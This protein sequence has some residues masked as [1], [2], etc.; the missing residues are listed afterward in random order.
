MNILF[1]HQSFP[2]QYRHVLRY[3]SK[4]NHRIV[5]LGINP[6]T[7]K[8]PDNVQYFRYQ[9]HRSNTVGLDPW[10]VDIDSKLIRG[11]ACASA[12]SNLKDQGFTP[13]IICAHSG[14]GEA[15]FIKD[16]WPHVPLLSYQE[17]YYNA[18]GFDYDFDPELQ[19]NTDWT[20]T[21]KLRLKNSNPLLMLEQSDWN[22]TPTKFQ[23][24]CFPSSFHNR[25]SVIHDGIDTELCSPS[26]HSTGFSWGSVQ[27]SSSHKLVTFVNRHIEPYRG[28]HTFIRS[29]PYILEQNPD[30]HIVIVG[31]EY[32]VS[33]GHSAPNNSW[34]EV[35]LS[36]IK[37]R[38]NPERLHFVG[39]LPY[40]KYLD[41]LQ[42][43]SCH[44]YLTYP[45]VLSWSLLEALS[46]GLPVV[47]SDTKPV[48]EV[49]CNSQNGLLVDFF[50]PE[51]VSLSV[52]RVL[53]D[54]DLSRYLSSNARPTALDQFSLNRCVPPHVDLIS[55]IS[56]SSV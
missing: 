50:S 10:L 36:E 53:Q 25:F 32:G 21:A 30:A 23:K 18:F 12:A 14:W 8:I 27:F 46:F 56:N 39:S 22:I 17:F 28:C 45:F 19:K 15:L 40:H 42:S 2:G 33:Y 35:F 4:S 49:I 6:L 34:K 51:A 41:L 13:N 48:H 9:P 52:S 11:Q 31:E 55:N 37:G 20:Y 5:G 38:Y 44:V 29:I 3:L 16:I 7:E 47:A 26:R 43:S 24:S 54:P 1:I